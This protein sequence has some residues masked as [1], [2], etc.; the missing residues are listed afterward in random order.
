MRFTLRIKLI[1]VMTLVVAATTLASMLVT[2][3]YVRRFYERK[4]EDDFK[5]EIRFFSER[6]IQRQEKLST[7]CL[8]LA[9]DPR[10]VNA[11]KSGKA[12]GYKVVREGISQFLKQEFASDPL[13]GRGFGKLPMVPPFFDRGGGGGK[14]SKPE[15][16]PRLPPGGNDQPVV[17]L[18]DA[19]GDVIQGSD[20]GRVLLGK[21]TRW[22]GRRGE[23]FVKAMKQ[24]VES[25]ELKQEVGYRL[26]K[27]PN[28]RSQLWSFIVTPVMAAGSSEPV[29]ALFVGVRA[30]DLGEKSLHAFTTAVAE[31]DSPA[32]RQAEAASSG[33]WLDGE[34]YSS[35][36]PKEARDPI[37]QEVGDRLA[38]GDASTRFISTNVNVELDGV[39]ESFRVLYR[40]LNPGS[41]FGDAAQVCAYSQR[42]LQEEEAALSLRIARIGGLSLLG[43]LA[44]I[45]LLTRGLVQPVR[46][47]VAG[48]EEVRKGNYDV[49][50][51]ATSGDEIGQLGKAFN[52]M[53]VG[54]KMN[55]K[56]QRLL[57]QV[58][59]RMVAEQLMNNEAALGGELREVTVLFCDIRG[60]T[61]MTSEMAPGEVIALLNEH[62]SAMTPLIYEHCG[63]VDKFVGD[64]IM[65]LFGA[66]SA[67]GDDVER[68][69]QCALRMV[70]C[71]DRLNAAG[72]WKFQV[73]IGIATGTVVA[74]CMGSEERLDYTVLG[75]RV[76]LASR[77]C[78][79]AGEGEV[80]ID[81]ATAAKLSGHATLVPVSDLALKGFSQAVQA[82]RVEAVV[83]QDWEIETAPKPQPTA[84]TP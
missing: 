58:A 70:E 80:L 57:S 39:T 51:P 34:I 83:A 20:A 84:R 53:V 75:E 62:M 35:T 12:E 11:V 23:S 5:A 27:E 47:L 21:K 81:D 73:G 76:N 15:L 60:F 56:Y 1:L 24:M 79:V 43:A 64:M 48:A 26:E 77:L 69:V 49:A 19:E 22:E 2:Q 10:L 4:F 25:A 61:S 9:E 41:V 17:A 31:G 78:S 29:G 18:L 55:Q 33:L 82:F 74:G 72:Q 68:A 36:I 59:D 50:L 44:L 63:V 14:G 71:R 3:E 40:V 7:A 46:A 37:A 16:P 28:G 45:I 6:Q 8:E 13:L 38:K 52:E 42:P 66:P 67:Y 65:A 30:S 54:L 32:E